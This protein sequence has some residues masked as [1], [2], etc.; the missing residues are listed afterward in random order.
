VYVSDDATLYVP[1]GT[2]SKYEATEGWKDFKNIV[3]IDPSGIATMAHHYFEV[4]ADAIFSIVKNDLEPLK[5]AIE[6][7]KNELFGNNN[8]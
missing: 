4:D 3:E 6:F 1:V 5:K 2:K 7:F 8:Q